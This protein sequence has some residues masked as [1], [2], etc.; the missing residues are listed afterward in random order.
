MFPLPQPD[1]RLITIRELHAGAL[2]GS[3]HGSLRVLRNR[4][5]AIALDSFDRWQ[6]QASRLRDVG[7]RQIRQVAR[8]SNLG[9]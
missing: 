6:G 1:S 9:G 8:G 2:E 5:F 3:A 7:L 4:N